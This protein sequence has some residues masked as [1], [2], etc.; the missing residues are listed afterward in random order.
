MEKLWMVDP[1]ALPSLNAWLNHVK[2]STALV[3]N[4]P[5]DKCL[6]IKLTYGDFG[7]GSLLGFTT[8]YPLPSC[9]LTETLADGRFVSAK[10]CLFS[11]STSYFTGG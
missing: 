7:D 1:I 9:K 10:N 6:M 11:G 3:S 4:P 2:P 5:Y 8:L